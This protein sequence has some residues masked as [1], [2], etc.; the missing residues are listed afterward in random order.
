M[1]ED[2]FNLNRAVRTNTAFPSSINSVYTLKSQITVT[3]LQHTQSGGYFAE[4]TFL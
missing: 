3:P 4:E 2:I 1:C